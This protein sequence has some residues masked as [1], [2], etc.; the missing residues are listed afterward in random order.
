RDA[1]TTAAWTDAVLR[2]EIP[3]PDTV[4]RQVATIVRIARTAG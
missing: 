4:A 2:G 1:Q 3:V